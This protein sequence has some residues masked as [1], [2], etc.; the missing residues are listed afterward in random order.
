MKSNCPPPNKNRTNG[1]QKE[2]QNA[3]LIL[4]VTENF[5]RDTQTEPN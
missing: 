5:E 2:N 1:Y 3:H 4:S